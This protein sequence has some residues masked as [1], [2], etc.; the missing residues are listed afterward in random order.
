MFIQDFFQMKFK[1]QKEI[2]LKLN[3]FV[4]CFWKLED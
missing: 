4:F 1:P 3:V 2:K